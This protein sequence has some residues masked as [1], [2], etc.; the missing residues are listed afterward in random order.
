MNHNSGKRRGRRYN[1]P[2]RYSPESTERTMMLNRHRLS[3]F[4][5]GIKEIMSNYRVDETVAST[6]IANVITKGSRISID[7]AKSFIREQE[8]NGVC[9]KEVSDEVCILLDRFSKYR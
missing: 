8:S 3:S 6:L 9:S 4:K 2:K 5:Y 1:E 7:S